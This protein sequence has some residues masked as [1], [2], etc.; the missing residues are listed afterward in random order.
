MP[1]TCE[2]AAAAGIAQLVRRFGVLGEIDAADLVFFVL[3]DTHGGLEH[4]GNDA[5]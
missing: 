5:R 3:T 2:Y 1:D 4:Q